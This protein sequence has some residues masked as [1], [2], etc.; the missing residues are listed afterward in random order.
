M[1]IINPATQEI[2]Q[3]VPED[4][5]ESIAEKFSE[6]KKGQPL[7]SAMQLQKRIDVIAKFHDL[8]EEEKE[9]FKNIQEILKLNNIKYN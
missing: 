7:W 9:E 3:K 1:T 5:K 8:L 2:I 6:L 4:S